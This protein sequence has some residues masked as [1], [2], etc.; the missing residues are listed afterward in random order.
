M[1]YDDVPKAKVA[2]LPHQHNMKLGYARVG[3]HP[4]DVVVHGHK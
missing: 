1:L 4:K 3:L 2:F